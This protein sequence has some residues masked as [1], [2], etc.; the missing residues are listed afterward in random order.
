MLPRI[1]FNKNKDIYSIP[2]FDLE[3]SDVEDFLAEL[4]SFHSEF[5]YCFAR[6][7]MADNMFLYMVGQFS[8]LER[9]S[10][11]PMALNVKDGRIRSMQRFI[12]SSVWREDEI[13]AKYRSMVNEHR[14]D[15]MEMP[16][17]VKKED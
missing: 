1:R 6:S 11:E 12:S 10:I 14:G 2:K 7:E 9:K 17:V 13:Y 15:E 16:F 3:R 8:E 5:R 4:K